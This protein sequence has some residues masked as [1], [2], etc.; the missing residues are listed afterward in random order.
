MEALIGSILAVGVVGSVLFLA[1]G[2]FWQRRATG[3][4]HLNH[5]LR[6]TNLFGF[7]SGCAQAVAGGR[8][9]PELLVN[10]GIGVLLLTPYVRV[11]ASAVYFAFFE[12]NAKYAGFTAFVLGVLTYSLFLR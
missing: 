3:A 7:W 5:A 1:A 4:I 10:L 12:R 9:S 8:W 11:A 6:G 2:L